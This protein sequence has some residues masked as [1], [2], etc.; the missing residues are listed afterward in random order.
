MGAVFVRNSGTEDKT[1]VGVRGRKEDERIL[2]EIG[3]EIAGFLRKVLKDYKNPCAKI[4][5]L[6]V[7]KVSQNKK[8]EKSLLLSFISENT[9]SS[10]EIIKRVLMETEKKESL[11]RRVI[12]EGSEEDFY[13]I[14]DR[15]RLWLG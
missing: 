1:G 3:E 7:E 14:T 11:I 13:S 6:I 2:S 4:Q 8:I 12:K 5:K 10:S 15:G 9:E